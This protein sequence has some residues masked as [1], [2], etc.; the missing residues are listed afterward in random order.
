[1]MKEWSASLM[2]FGI[3]DLFFLSDC[4][5]RNSCAIDTILLHIIFYIHKEFFTASH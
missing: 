3:F 5:L 1:M 2:G 4:P